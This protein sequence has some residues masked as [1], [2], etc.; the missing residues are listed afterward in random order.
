MGLTFIHNSR[1]A[2]YENRYTYINY[3]NEDD[4][5]RDLSAYSDDDES[6]NANWISYSQHLFNSIL[7]F[8]ELKKILVFLHSI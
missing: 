7:I 4:N 3:K 5:V 8:N 1:S 2:S 6:G